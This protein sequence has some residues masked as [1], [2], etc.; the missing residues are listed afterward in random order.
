MTLLLRLLLV[1]ALIGLI[2]L[3]A[4]FFR[5]VGPGE[6]ALVAAVLVLA[7]IV[8][9]VRYLVKQFKKGYHGSPDINVRATKKTRNESD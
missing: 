2:A 1:A 4:S 7:F 3:A 6:V 9:I 8:E 5:R